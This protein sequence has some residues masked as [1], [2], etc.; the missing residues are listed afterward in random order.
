MFHL[1]SLALVFYFL[2]IRLAPMIAEG[3]VQ[4]KRFDPRLTLPE[5]N[6]LLLKASQSYKA[7]L[8]LAVYVEQ[9]GIAFDPT[10]EVTASLRTN[11]AHQYL[12]NT[13]KR[14]AERLAVSAT[15]KAKAISASDADPFLE[16]TRKA[17]GEYLDNLPDFICQQVVER[18]YDLGGFGVWNKF[19][20][21]TYE[22]MY[23]GGL[24]SY[25]PV[26][27]VNRPITRRMEQARGSYSTGDF[28]AGLASL[29]DPKTQ[30]VFKAAGK[31]RLGER[32]TLVY[33]FRVPL[34]T[35]DLEVKAENEQAIIAGYSGTVWIDEETQQILRMDQAT[36]QL[37]ESLSVTSSEGSVRYGRVKIQNLRGGFF[38]PLHAEFLIADQRQ[39]NFFRN[40]ISFNSY[41]KFET[42]IKILDDPIPLPKKPT[43]W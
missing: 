28:A 22:L 36:D 1:L 3:A 25:T 40:V 9:Y 8:D 6:K 35:S 42:D 24:E 10:P 19:D 18:Y 23:N 7:E 29:F 32:Q 34:E 41:R 13:V 26:N 31:E 43:L 38:L 12:I 4:Q 15:R 16:K 30:A 20:T 2:L 39:K 11:G 33:D 27:L 14:V 5:F 21:L 17:V 37:P